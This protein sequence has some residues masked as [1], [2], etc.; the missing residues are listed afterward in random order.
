MSDINQ[1]EDKLNNINE[2]ANSVA[3]KANKD[4][5]ILRHKITCL[6]VLIAIIA[7]IGATIAIY[8]IYSIKSLFYDIKTQENTYEQDIQSDNNCNQIG[9]IG[10]SN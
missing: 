7:V 8:S 5:L 10:Y 3:Y 6:T 9:I 1:I 4:I 2:L